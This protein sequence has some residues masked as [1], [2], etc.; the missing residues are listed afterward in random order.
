VRKWRVIEAADTTRV[1]IRA[2]S[3]NL[4]HGRDAPPDPSLFTLRSKLLRT[5]ERNDTHVQVNRDLFDEFAGVLAR[6]EWDVALLQESPP[7]WANPLAVA[8]R[9]HPHRALTARNRVPA[10]Q[11]ALH[12]WNPDLIGSWEGGSNLTLA[13]GD[14]I[15]E[16]R[17]LV[18][19]PGRPER[20]VMAF[21]R[22]GNGLCISNLHATTRNQALAEEELREAAAAATGWA[23][24]APLIL[25]GDFNLRPERSDVFAEL[26]EGH[27]LRFPTA[28]DAIDHLLARDLEVLEP[29]RRWH[30]EAREIPSDG[31]ALR[32]SDHAPVEALFTG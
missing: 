2:L 31:L 32:L 26:E 16:R 12:T 20:R 23:G 8:C 5:T 24:D 21:T 25:G 14:G 3:W 19:R 27:G 22:L 17:E 28:P 1:E 13:R 4:F 11:G 29:P 18:L 9:A 6:A 30:P 10:I 15:A 7:R